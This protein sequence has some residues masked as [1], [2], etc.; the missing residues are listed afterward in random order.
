MNKEQI[1]GVLESLGLVATI[2]I[3]PTSGTVAAD[4]HKH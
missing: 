2:A 4:T 1:I 3:E